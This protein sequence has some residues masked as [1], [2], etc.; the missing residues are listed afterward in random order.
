MFMF[1]ITIHRDQQ[2]DDDAQGMHFDPESSSLMPDVTMTQ[3]QIPMASPHITS[4]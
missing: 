1:G 2:T 3:N 4:E